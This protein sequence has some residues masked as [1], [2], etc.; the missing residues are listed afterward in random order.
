MHAA[1]KDDGIFAVL[2]QGPKGVIHCSLSAIGDTLQKTFE[3]CK[4]I[5]PL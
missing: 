3:I 1:R 4:T 5:A 2:V